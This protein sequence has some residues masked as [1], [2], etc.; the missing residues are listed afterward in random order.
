MAL[1]RI[2][3]EFASEIAQHDWRDAPWRT[4]RA[5]HHRD[6]DSPARQ[7]KQIL[8]EEEADSV[9]TNVMWVAA[10][11][12]GYSDP[13]FDVQE[14]ADACGVNTSRFA[15]RGWIDNG[16]RQSYGEYMRPG[17]RHFDP[18]TEVVTTDTSDAYHAT[19]R[20]PL[21]QSGYQNTP[22]RTFP[23]NQV[24]ANWR[25]CRCVTLNRG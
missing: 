13:N 20:C 2:A 23:A 16:L 8:N 18:L 6:S 14:F 21:F 15:S 11:V 22:L 24:P 3:Q 9:R 12:L 17:T 4:D 19:T 25:P 10:Q 5:G 7:T 1:S